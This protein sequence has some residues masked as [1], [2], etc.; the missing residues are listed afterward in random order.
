MRRTNLG[1]SLIL[2]YLPAQRF[3]ATALSLQMACPQ[4][5]YGWRCMGFYLSRI[6]LALLLLEWGVHHLPVF[7]LARSGTLK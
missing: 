4:R 5:S 7:A 1:V 6:A 2:F 3:P